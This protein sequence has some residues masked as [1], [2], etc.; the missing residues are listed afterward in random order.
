MVINSLP[1][2]TTDDHAVRVGFAV[3]SVRPMVTTSQR[4][5][6]ASLTQEVQ[7][8]TSPTTA[9]ASAATSTN[10]SAGTSMVLHSVP[11]G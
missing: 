1:H 10:T 5:K 6:P 8:N 3:A 11:N 4:A 2:D 9:S 7:T